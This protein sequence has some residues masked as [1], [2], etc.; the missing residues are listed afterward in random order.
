M[1]KRKIINET[2]D[3]VKKKMLGEGTGHDWWHVKR[4]WKS[5]KLISKGESADLFVV[6]LAALLHDIA[7]WKFQKDGSDKAGS[8]ASRKWL[9]KLGVSEKDIEHIAT[10]VDSVSFRGAGVADKHLSLGSKVVQDADRLDA[11]GAIGIAR[12]FA[13]GGSV[14]SQ[15]HD[16]VIKHTMHKSFE[17]YKTKRSTS[18]NHFYEKLLL[19]KGRM[20]TRTGKK[21]ATKRHKFMENYLKTFYAEWDGKI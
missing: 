16:P 3:F 5:A 11:L 17:E 6:E 4:V 20:N 14:G 13:Y 18:I 7:D 8:K 1:N 9:K 21:L 12:C 10:I 2:A 15:I 19:L